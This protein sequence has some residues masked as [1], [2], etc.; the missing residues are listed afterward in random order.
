VLDIGCGRGRW[1]YLIK[2]KNSNAKITG[3]EIYKPYV[4]FASKLNVYDKVINKNFTNLSMF[5]YKSFDTVIAIEVIEHV[6]KDEGKKL[7]EELERIA[8]SK[9]II[10]TPL[11]FYE[12]DFK[13]KNECHKS[14]WYKTEF[15]SLGY[16]VN[17]YNFIWKGTILDKNNKPK[18][19]DV[20]RDWLMCVKVMK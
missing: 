7:L 13:L 5:N 17:Q 14:G 20:D 4:E 15:E 12:L 11:G 18:K 8:K 19:I 1:G 9:I 2:E 6:K 10:T 3:I 16:K